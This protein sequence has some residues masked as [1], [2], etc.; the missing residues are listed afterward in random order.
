[1]GTLADIEGLRE[2]GWSWTRIAA[3][4]RVSE[5]EVRRWST[6]KDVPANLARPAVLDWGMCLIVNDTQFPFIDRALWEVVCQI[7]VDMEITKLIWDGDCIDFPQLSSFKHNAYKL[8]TA[9]QDV[10]DFHTEVRDPLMKGL[11]RQV[12]EIWNDGN[13]EYRYVRYCDHNAGALGSFPAPRDFLELPD[14]V[15]W[16]PYGKAV[17]TLL[18]PKLLVSHGWQARKHS[19]ATAKA[20]AEDVGGGMSVITGHTHRVGTYYHSTPGG[21]VQASYEVGHMC[22]PTLLP[23]AVEGFQNWQKTAGTLVRYQLNGDAFDA[24]ILT[25]LGRRENL[26]VVEDRTYE[27]AR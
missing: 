19:G 7:A 4:Y 14:H 2:R 6:G 15:V 3:F 11:G 23:K 17:G 22:D 24:N 12:D 9:H 18:T 8:T 26:V 20:N 1:M 10:K 25:V 13:H 27:I 5:R 16:E 21:G